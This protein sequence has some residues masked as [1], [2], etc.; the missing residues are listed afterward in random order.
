MTTLKASQEYKEE[1]RK[2]I[3]HLIKT[4]NFART[5]KA[6]AASAKDPQPLWGNY[7]FREAVTLETG[8]P[9]I[10]KTTFDYSLLSTISEGKPFLGIK[11]P[12]PITTLYFDYESSDPLIK[13]REGKISSPTDFPNFLI[14]NIAEYSFENEEEFIPILYNMYKFD[15]LVIDNMLTAFDT[16]D[17]NDNAE[18]KKKVKKMRIIAEKLNCSIVILHHPSKANLPG[19]RKASGAFAWA[20][21]SDIL[22]NFNQTSD[23]DVIEI[24]TAKNR[25]AEGERLLYIR[26]CGDCIFEKCEAPDKNIILVDTD[27]ERAK[28]HI[29]TYKGVHSR[30]EILI[31]CTNSGYNFKTATVNK[32]IWELAKEDD[33]M[34]K[35]GW[36]HYSIL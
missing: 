10:G 20:R 36:G 28:E 25:W 4:G 18:A 31:F 17:E 22:L 12:H 16:L 27:L 1:I 29:L 3:H 35:A 30:S 33:R 11:P 34:A 7:F 9:G 21:H 2:E 14:I 24:E 23:P 6:I 15:M 19:T 5:I 13:M 32:A 26:K 8:D